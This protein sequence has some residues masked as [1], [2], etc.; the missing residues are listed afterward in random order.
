[1]TINS[2]GIVGS[3]A[4]G[5]GIA[6]LFLQSGVS[7]C[8]FDSQ[9]SALIAASDYLT[10]TFSTLL[11]K[12]KIDSAQ[13][14]A[15]LALYRPVKSLDQLAHCDLIVEAIVENLNA[16]Q[17]LFKQLESIVRPDCLLATNTSSLS[18]TAIAAGC[19]SPARVAG[20]HFF[21]PVPLMKV[22]EIIRA[23]RTEQTVI[24]QLVQ[25]IKPTGHMPVVC[26]DTPGFVINHA[27]RG[28]GT[29]AL[30][31]IGEGVIAPSV[32]EPLKFAMIDDIMRE[33]VRFNGLG[34]R[35]GPFEL[36][37]LTALDVSHPVMESIYKQYYDEPRFRPSVITAQRLS[38]GLLGKKTTA[39]FYDYASGAVR[40]S[41]NAAA[42]LEASVT[43]PKIVWIGPGI[44]RAS[45]VSLIESFGVAIEHTALP[46][47]DVLIILLPAGKDCTASALEMGVSPHR[48]VALDTWFELTTNT[49]NP[50]TVRRVLM[51]NPATDPSI[52]ASAV[53]LFSM[54]QAQVSLISDSPGFVAPRIIAMMIAIACEMA[55]AGVAS[56]S[57]IDQAVKLGLG[58]PMGPLSMGNYLGPSRVL[59]LLEDI[60]DITKDPRYR[61]SQWL[62]RRALL[63]MSL[64]E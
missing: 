6:Q 17:S 57:A 43:I 11:T 23:A 29:E 63:G 47:V 62:R 10:S 9:E 41:S 59:G 35:L 60:Y 49:T 18:V 1:V 48:S 26:S 51:T 5:R 42:A 36:L 20:L 34:F 30:R 44:N 38:A 15:A 64:L 22:V 28:Y 32:S 3:G 37:D 16:K 52:A 24:D 55:Q 21:N 50:S 61:P 56:A 12:G 45:V 25:L 58:Y 7:V 14:A 33:Q 2:I 4:M 53:K 31:L 39:G 54:D 13:M 19:S 8:L 46:S 40:P 27:G